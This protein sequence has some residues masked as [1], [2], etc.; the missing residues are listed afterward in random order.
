MA[1]DMKYTVGTADTDDSSGQ[2]SESLNRRLSSLVRLSEMEQRV[3]P[4]GSRSGTAILCYPQAGPT[5]A[6]DLYE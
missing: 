6:R 4:S 3:V 5:L 2:D 1:T